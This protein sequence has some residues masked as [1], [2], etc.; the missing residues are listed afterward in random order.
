MLDEHLLEKMQSKA[1]DPARL[2]TMKDVQKWFVG[3]PA[4]CL[5]FFIPAN[6]PSEGTLIISN[7]STAPSKRD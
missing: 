7:C 2:P 6:Q 3:S 4:K 5:L 1:E